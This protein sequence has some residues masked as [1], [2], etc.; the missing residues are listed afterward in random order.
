MS[1]CFFSSSLFHGGAAGLEISLEQRLVHHMRLRQMRSYAIKPIPTKH[2][3]KWN[4]NIASVEDH[5]LDYIR[6]WRQINPSYRYEFLSDESAE[7]WVAAS[8]TDRPEV[9]R[10]YLAL[11]DDILRAD[12]LRYLILFKEGGVYSD[13]DTEALKSIDN[14]IPLKHKDEANIVIGLEIDEPD[15]MW[16]DWADNFT[17]CQSTM[18]ASPGHRVYE[19]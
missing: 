17:F 16:T 13:I 12:L 5:I 11:K 19:I 9:V 6:S 1:L 18:M 2:W 14:W 10:A 3:Q 15:S 8:Y 4:T 7:T